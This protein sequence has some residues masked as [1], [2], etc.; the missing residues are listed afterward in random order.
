MT[1]QDEAMDL[2]TDVHKAVQLGFLKAENNA[3][4][5]KSSSSGSISGNRLV[6]D[7]KERLAASHLSLTA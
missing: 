7:S 3:S 2:F 5:R 1:I 6:S 4:E